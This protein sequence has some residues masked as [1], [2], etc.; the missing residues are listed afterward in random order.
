MNVADVRRRVQNKVGDTSG[1][2]I[3]PAQ[4]LDWINDGMLEI[5]RRTQQPQATASTVTVAGQSAYA[6]ATFSADVLR[7]RSVLCNGMLLQAISLEQ[8]DQQF[9]DRESSSSSAAGTPQWFWV[10]ADQINLWPRPDTAGQTLKLFYVKRP[11]PVTGDADV[12][13]IPLHMHPDLVSY[14]YAQ[15]LDT[16]GSGDRADR[17]TD[18]FIGGTTTAAADAEWPQRASYPHVTVSADDMVW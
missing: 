2:E 9:G 13:G 3:T 5:A 7:L 1:A 4:V 8:A 18:R 6:T 14:V 15:V 12:P 16:I 17:M 10:W 11:A